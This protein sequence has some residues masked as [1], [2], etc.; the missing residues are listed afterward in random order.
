MKIVKIPLIAAAVL[1]LGWVLCPVPLGRRCVDPDEVMER[2]LFSLTSMHAP[3][4]GRRLSLIKRN[5]STL[6]EGGD[7]IDGRPVW[8]LRLKPSR[9]D[10]PWKQVW[11]DKNTGAI[12]ACRDWSSRNEIKRSTKTSGVSRSPAQVPAQK[13]NLIVHHC[14]GGESRRDALRK[15]RGLLGYTFPRPRYVPACFELAV[16]EV[17]NT[18]G[19]LHLVYSDGLYVLSVFIGPTADRAARSIQ[20]NRAYDWGQG[21]AFLT[22]AHGR[23]ALIVADLPVE[24]IEKIAGSVQ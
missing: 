4:P 21:L 19:D 3:I 5:Y 9:K 8:T 7:T 20:A 2:P 18:D 15:A 17:D 24:E 22:S 10:F 6:V 1:V 13:L 11:V 16:V 12:R 14:Y 23:S